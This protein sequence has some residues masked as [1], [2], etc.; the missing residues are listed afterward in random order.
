M[1]NTKSFISQIDT[2]SLKTGQQNYKI[3]FSIPENLPYFDGHFPGY[4]VLPA[5]AVIDFS[6]EF[7]KIILSK[8]EVNIKSIRSAKFYNVIRPND[9]IT[10]EITPDK[11]STWTF[12][13]AN[14]EKKAADLTVVI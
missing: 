3:G 14:R 2:H 10:V 7:L 5:I 4:P 8:Q 9:D 11:N 6:F 13:W 12:K 1:I